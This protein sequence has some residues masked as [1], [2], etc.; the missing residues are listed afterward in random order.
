MTD[1]SEIQRKEA[2]KQT[3]TVLASRILSRYHSTEACFTEVQI[4]Y[5]TSKGYVFDLWA[6]TGRVG[7][8]EFK[9]LH[10]LLVVLAAVVFDNGLGPAALS[11][12]II[13][14]D[15]SQVCLRHREWA[16]LSS[17][18]ESAGRVLSCSFESG[19]Q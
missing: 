7:G 2:N 11:F 14:N 17:H 10:C 13:M 8:C 18:S 16:T 1:R 9:L 3:T 4:Q 12:I 15:V 5:T 6:S 19:T